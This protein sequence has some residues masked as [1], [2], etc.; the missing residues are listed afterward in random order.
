MPP[1]A[2][3]IASKEGS[4]VIPRAVRRGRCP[5]SGAER[6]KYPWGAS[7][8]TADAMGTVFVCRGGRLCPPAS[9]CTVIDRADRAVGPYGGSID[10]QYVGRAPCGPPHDSRSIINGGAHGPRPTGRVSYRLV[11]RQGGQSRPPLR[12]VTVPAAFTMR[13][14]TALK[15]ACFICRRQRCAAFPAKEKTGLTSGF[16]LQGCRNKER[17]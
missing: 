6:N 15:T 8:R 17:K 7:A 4:G 10:S 5:R 12:M 16:F 2:A 3:R 1:A 9:N 14:D 11:R 13:R